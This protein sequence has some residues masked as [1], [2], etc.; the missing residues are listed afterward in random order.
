V[1]SYRNTNSSLLPTD[2]K[3]GQHSDDANIDR[4]GHDRPRAKVLIRSSWQSVNIG[5]IGHT[6]GLLRLLEEHIPQA[7]L[8]L[9]ANSLDYGVE[10]MLRRD[11]PEVIIFQDPKD[12]HGIPRS[13]EGRKLWAEADFLVHGSGPYV[14]S[15]DVLVAWSKT[16]RPFGVYGVTIEAFDDKLVELLSGADFVFCRDTVSLRAAFAAGV[17]CEYLEFAPD[18]AFAAVDRDDVSAERFLIENQLED[19]DF[20]CVIS[21]LRYTPYFKIQNRRATSR[22]QR[23]ARISDAHK[24]GDHE[25]L[26]EVIIQWIRKTGKKVLVCPEMTYEIE[27]TKEQLVDALP[28]DV[29]RNVVW[30]STY[31]RPD[32]ASSVYSRAVALVSMEMHSPILA[33]AVGTPAFYIRLPSDT[34]KGQMWRD[35]G[36]PEWIFEIDDSDGDDI[37]KA[38]LRFL[39]EPERTMEKLTHARD[40]IAYLQVHSMRIVRDA[41][42]RLATRK[43]AVPIKELRTSR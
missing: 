1:N 25:R 7:Q 30:R 35:I 15:R 37:A 18:A 13:A 12:E 28:E 16:E 4:T 31:W 27:L 10:E 36:L 39:A 14:V 3:N 41:I 8:I 38:L 22:E 32:E 29:R 9:W 19:G 34:C 40:R 26:R 42:D 5:D 6:P 24:H 2:F 20:I 11:F 43:A 21:R 23:L 17:R 33:C